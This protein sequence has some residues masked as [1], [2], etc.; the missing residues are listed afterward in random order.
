VRKAKEASARKVRFENET[1]IFYEK[2]PYLSLNI[3]PSNSIIRKDSLKCFIFSNKHSIYWFLNK[4]C[5]LCWYIPLAAKVYSF[6][7][8]VNMSLIPFRD[9]KYLKLLSR[10]ETKNSVKDSTTLR[11]MLNNEVY[12]TLF[13]LNSSRTIPSF[14]TRSRRSKKNK[15]PQRYCWC[16]SKWT[17]FQS[18]TWVSSHWKTS[19]LLI[20][21]L[22]SESSWK[23]R[24]TAN[25]SAWL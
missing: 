25:S 21:T 12:L 14:C 9:L 20:W 4:S 7:N 11:H 5:R 24:S 8:F 15:Y 22:W 17:K 16:R 6:I 1:W 3:L 10:M 13:R 23:R 2:L 19:Y 18:E